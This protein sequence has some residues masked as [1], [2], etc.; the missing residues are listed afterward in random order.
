MQNNY[1][2]L[3]LLEARNNQP[4]HDPALLVQV[5][6][7]SALLAGSHIKWF[8]C[9]LLLCHGFCS[10][11]RCRFQVSV[12]EGWARLFPVWRVM[13]TVMFWLA[14]RL[15]TAFALEWP[16]SSCSSLC[17]WSKSRAARTP[18]LRCTMGESESIE[19]WTSR[20]GHTAI[21]STQMVFLQQYC[22]C[23]LC[24]QMGFDL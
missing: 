8:S 17:S 10:V 14:T 11:C 15:C 21:V 16:C 20:L 7:C 19:P 13:W 12:K 23:Q 22:Y 18:E 1:F 24:Y 9:F 4:P 5:G 3:T 6:H 2:I